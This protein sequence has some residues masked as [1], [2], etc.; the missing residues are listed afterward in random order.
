MFSQTLTEKSGLYANPV[1]GMMLQFLSLVRDQQA[2]V[3]VV[4]PR[5]DGSVPGGTW[6]PLW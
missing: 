3:A 5:W 4:A 2:Q 1:F 6:W